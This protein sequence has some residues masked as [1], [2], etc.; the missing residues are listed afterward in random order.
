MRISKQLGELEQRRQIQMTWHVGRSGPGRLICWFIII[1][2]PRLIT[3]G[4]GIQEIILGQLGISGAPVIN[5]NDDL[6]A[7]A[8][9]V[10]RD[11][12]FIRSLANS[13]EFNEPLTMTGR[14]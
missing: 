8:L 13:G 7:H 1:T 9:P 11:L 6:V 5:A 2:I 12:R 4:F 10:T 3:T 14:R